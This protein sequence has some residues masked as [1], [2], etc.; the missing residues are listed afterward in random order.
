MSAPRCV[1]SPA[2]VLAW[3]VAC[4]AV[5]LASADKLLFAF[6]GNVDSAELDPVSR[7][8]CDPPDCLDSLAR[9]R[10]PVLSF[11]AFRRRLA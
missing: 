4:W 7:F 6:E 2:M 10:Y 5:A 3:I 11:S 9:H 8:P 1:N